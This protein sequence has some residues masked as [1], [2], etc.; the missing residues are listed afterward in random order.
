LKTALAAAKL[1][2]LNG[3][4]RQREETLENLETLAAKTY[5]VFVK[6]SEGD[7]V[8][9]RNLLA[10]FESFGTRTEESR[11][12]L[13]I[14]ASAKQ[15]FNMDEY[16]RYVREAKSKAEAAKQDR[17]R[18]I[19]NIFHMIRASAAEAKE[20]GADTSLVESHIGE[21]KIAYDNGS[22]KQSVE[23]LA[24][25]DR[26]LDGHHVEMLRRRRELE[27][28]QLRKAALWVAEYEPILAEAASYGFDL[29][30]AQS[31]L[32]AAKTALA[33]KD[34]V[35]ASKYG[36]YVR[37]TMRLMEREL[38]NKRLELGTIKHVEA[39]MCVKCTQESVYAYPN[40]SRK[41]LT[42]GFMNLE[43]KPVEPPLVPAPVAA[44][45]QVEARPAPTQPAQDAA[46]TAPGAK[47]RR[48]L[49]W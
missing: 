1:A 11:R 24:A 19:G 34:P 35:N 37:D 14:A 32:Q 39:M 41:C 9:L 16:S 18:E 26:S 5:S 47:K 42:C 38:D 6:H 2:F 49:R 15:T 43:P 30:D 28:T 40:G 48:L 27:A 46:V 31:K 29:K 25:V 7:E 8:E 12:Y 21:A 23:L 33:N 4:P 45:P 10:D 3:T 44:A 36:R 17:I 20:L 22:F 13:E